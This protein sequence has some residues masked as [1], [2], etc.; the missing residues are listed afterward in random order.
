MLDRIIDGVVTDAVTLTMPLFEFESE[1]SLG[2]PWQKWGCPTP[3]TAELI[4]Q[5]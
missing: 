5:A 3:L 1:L 4:F 2:T